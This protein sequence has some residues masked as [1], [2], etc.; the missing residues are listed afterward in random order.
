M[1]NIRSNDRTL[2]S[3]QFRRLIERDNYS[4]WLA[5]GG[6]T[7]GERAT[8]RV[9]AIL[10]EHKPEPLLKDVA[11]AVHAIVERAEAQYT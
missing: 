3:A 4:N 9:E 11:K 8:E 1:A 5:K 7:L 2:L 6:K 10:T